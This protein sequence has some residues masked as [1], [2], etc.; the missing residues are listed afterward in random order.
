[1]ELCG[2]VEKLRSSASLKR[3]LWLLSLVYTCLMA[4]VVLPVLAG[5]TVISLMPA[6][7]LPGRIVAINILLLCAT[8]AIF[9]LLIRRIVKIK[10]S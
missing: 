1:L 10:P 4:A 9:I 8:A 7:R 3:F 5:L 2:L 6:C